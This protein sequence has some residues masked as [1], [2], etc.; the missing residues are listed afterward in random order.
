MMHKCRL[1]YRDDYYETLVNWWSKWNFPILLKSSLPER[2]FVV[3][4]EGI[5]LYAAP[6]Y[7]S[8]S[9]WCWIGFITGNKEA[10]KKYRKDALKFLL[11]NI[12]HYM[13]DIGYDLIMTVSSSP[14][15][16]KLFEDAEYNSSSKNIVEYIKKI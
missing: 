9:S 8:D 11:Y 14:V 16:K 15:L 10:E 13:K 4:A 12:E 1:E 5:D 6:V 7:V 3:S 2:I